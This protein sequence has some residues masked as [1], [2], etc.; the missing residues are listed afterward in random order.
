MSYTVEILPNLPVIHVKYM[1]QTTKDEIIVAMRDVI[2]L[3]LTLTAP[4]IFH[5]IDV[6]EAQTD[7]MAMMGVFKE[8][9]QNAHPI[10]MHSTEYHRMFIGTNDMAK[11]SSQMMTLPQFGGMKVPLFKTLDDALRYVHQELNILETSE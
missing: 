4:K 9:S 5:I 6:A 2:Q 8:M 1:G 3:A 7:F 11:L 10:P